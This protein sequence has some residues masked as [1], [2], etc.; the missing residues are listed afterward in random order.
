MLSFRVSEDVYGLED[1]SAS[2]LVR[3]VEEGT[4]PMVGGEPERGSLLEK[5][6][7]G[8]HSQEPV[9]L[10]NT[11]LA[12]VGIVLEAWAVEVDGDLPDDVQELRLAVGAAFR[13]TR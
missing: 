5:L 11:E 12:I 8:V 9:A 3:R 4:P 6:R 1:E 7:D 2:E 10:D 13:H